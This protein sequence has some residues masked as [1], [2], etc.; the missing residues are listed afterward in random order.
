MHYWLYFLSQA[1]VST[2]HMCCQ[3]YKSILSWW[4]P[5]REGLLLSKSR[6]RHANHTGLLRRDGMHTQRGI[7]VRWLGTYVWW[8][9]LFVLVRDVQGWVAFFLPLPLPPRTLKYVLQHHKKGFDVIRY[10]TEAHK[11]IIQLWWL[12]LHGQLKSIA[13]EVHSVGAQCCQG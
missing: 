7:T 13:H 2:R 1:A 10:S 3:L 4:L 8:L 9:T 12:C 11:G 5:L 6:W